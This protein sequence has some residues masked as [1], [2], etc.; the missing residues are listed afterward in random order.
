MPYPGGKSGSGVYQRIITLMPP[1][2]RYFEPFLG[3]GAIF[4]RKRPAAVNIGIELDPA[5]VARWALPS[6]SAAKAFAVGSGGAAGPVFLAA[7]AVVVESGGERRHVSLELA[8][9]AGAVGSGGA[10][11]RGGTVPLEV[12]AQPGGDGGSGDIPCGDT[13]SAVARSGG[14][15]SGGGARWEIWRADGIDVLRNYRFRPD[16]LV[17][18]DPPYL[19]GTRSSGRLYGCEMTD[20]QH[21]ALLKIV[22]RLPCMVIISGYWSEMYGRQL[23]AWRHI[24]FDAM[25]RGGMATEHLWLN[26]PAAVELHDYRY[27]GKNRRERE[28]LKRQKARWV[29]RL[30]RMDDLKRGAL[31]SAIQEYSAAVSDVR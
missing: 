12:A 22:K 28:Q 8:A 19:M 26:F 23:A 24:E 15:D 3:G 29:Q 16:D 21:R 7:S 4:Q 2:Q 17:Y 13:G 31:L 1:H 18:C 9:S 11:D 5:I 20:D 10:G 30:G 25:T 6:E 14:V 27:L